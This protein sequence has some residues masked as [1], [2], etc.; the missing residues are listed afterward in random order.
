MPTLFNNQG[1][2]NI[3]RS[4][5][6]ANLF[7]LFYGAGK[8]SLVPFLPLYF[9]AI[10]MSATQVGILS[11]SKALVWYIGVPIWL[12]LA[13]RT[14]KTKCILFYAVIVASVSSILI[15]FLPIMIQD[16][17]INCPE[18]LSAGDK[19]HKNESEEHFKNI[20]SFDERYG[21]HQVSSTLKPIQ[22]V[23]VSSTTPLSTYQLSKNLI[24]DFLEQN[25]KK[26]SDIDNFLFK[27]ILTKDFPKWKIKVLHKQ[28]LKI[29]KANNQDVYKH[30]MDDIESSGESTI[31]TTTKISSLT[32]TNLNLNG[33]QKKHK[34]LKINALADKLFI[35]MQKDQYKYLSTKQFIDKLLELKPD[36]LSML[37]R[38]KLEVLLNRKIENKGFE[39]DYYRSRRDLTV[40][41][42]NLTEAVKKSYDLLKKQVSEVFDDVLNRTMIKSDTFMWICLIVLIGELL[43]CPIEALSDNSLY[44]L[45]EELDCINRYGRHISF[46]NFGS[47]ITGF[48]IPLI[49]YQIPCQLSD[50]IFG[51]NVHFYAYVFFL[52]VCLIFVPCYPVYQNSSDNKSL[53]GMSPLA[54]F[55]CCIDCRHFIFLMTTF[56]TGIIQGSLNTFLFW[57]LEKMVNF[58]YYILGIVVS[59]NAMV[60]WIVHKYG[61][62]LVPVMKVY[63]SGSVAL[64]LIAVQLLSISFVENAWAAV[65]VQLIN[66]LG[67]TFLWT[68]INFHV[69]MRMFLSWNNNAAA[70]MRKRVRVFAKPS[71]QRTMNYTLTSLHQGLAFAVGSFTSGVA[72]DISGGTLGPY[73]RGMSV[74]CGC[75]VVVYLFFT[76]MCNIKGRQF[77]NFVDSDD[78][79]CKENEQLFNRFASKNKGKSKRR[80]YIKNKKKYKQIMTSSSSD[81]EDW[82]EAALSKDEEKNRS[83]TIN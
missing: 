24:Q 72:Y 10:G 61:K 59:L 74:I 55:L 47:C 32:K 40:N 49:V 29:L 6:F 64:V 77:N 34:S 54:C 42:Q 73:L 62:Q 5:T 36:S 1:R 26:E 16:V 14:S 82:L 21:F 17:K 4:T 52:G 51:F 8:A 12:L 30:F 81:E 78:S 69:N 2:W 22:I 39:D 48:L 23:T 83:K 67:Q 20:S 75:W 13:K 79:D 38:K 60:Q 80:G 7:H 46:L 35:L 43:S 15:T 53:K 65:F 66:T 41:N 25:P 58:K 19:I 68:V 18:S 57:E 50:Y 56:L 76:Y 28:I 33:Q 11:A 9:K 45:L 3:D 63:L 31:Q 44:D 37:Q 70:N 27:N 71:Q